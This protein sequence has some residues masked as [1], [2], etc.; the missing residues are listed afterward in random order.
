MNDMLITTQ[1]QSLGVHSSKL[2]NDEHTCRQRAAG[3]NYL[4]EYE[5]QK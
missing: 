1:V 2:E 5:E 3:G 4:K